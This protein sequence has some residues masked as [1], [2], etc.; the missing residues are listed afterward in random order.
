[1]KEGWFYLSDLPFEAAE[2]VGDARFAFDCLG[3]DGDDG[4]SSASAISI[5]GRR[6]RK[7]ISTHP[8]CRIRFPLDGNADRFECSI[9]INDDVVWG[10]PQAAFVVYGDGS[11]LYRSRPMRATDPPE[12]VSL[13]VSG[14]AMLQLE[15]DMLGDPSWDHCVWANARVRATKQGRQALAEASGKRTSEAIKQHEALLIDLGSNDSGAAAAAAEKLIRA[16]PAST[17][18]AY[19]FAR[20]D[21][22]P[23]PRR[24]QHLL[25]VIKRLESCHGRPST[26]SSPDWATEYHVR[27]AAQRIRDHFREESSPSVLLK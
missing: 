16:L 4:R 17:D 25:G 6:F 14:V 27:Q 3:Y 18:A 26:D 15:C 24:A 9:G 22:G 11:E 13:D 12:P 7:G 2:R 20:R 8:P 19:H 21:R 10:T 23:G 5:L 1:M